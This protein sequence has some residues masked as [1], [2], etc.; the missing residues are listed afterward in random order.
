MILWYDLEDHLHHFWLKNNFETFLVLSQSY[1]PK[2][3]P[4][5]KNC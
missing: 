2:E 3:D 1:S 5:P 4:Y